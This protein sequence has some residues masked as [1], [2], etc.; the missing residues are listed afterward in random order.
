MRVVRT[1]LLLAAVTG[2]YGMPQIGGHHSDG[3]VDTNGGASGHAGTSP[4]D[5]GGGAADAGGGLDGGAGASDGLAGTFGGGAAGT[6]LGGMGGSGGSNAVFVSGPCIVSPDRASAVEVFAR[7]SDTRIYRRAFDGRNWGSWSAL[8]GLDGTLLDA[9]S[10]LDCAASS[11][12]IHIVAAGV[13]PV[14]SLQHA[15]GFGTTY[16]PFVRE[17]PSVAIAQSPSIALLTNTAFYLGWAGSGQSPALFYFENGSNAVERTPITLLGS[18]VV[19]A[20]DISAQL[21]GLFFAAFDSDGRLAI[22]RH[23]TSS[24][25]AAWVDAT[26]IESPGIFAFSPTVCAESGSSGSFSVN[27]AAVTGHELWFAG[28]DRLSGWPGFSQWVP[29]GKDAVSSPDCVVLRENPNL[30][31][32]IH[33]VMLNTHGTLTDLVGN[34]MSWVTTDLGPPPSR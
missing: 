16:N 7:A 26:T 8:I 28:T 17:L 15:F 20:V 10:D 19:S 29:I 13:N 24:G 14:G 11:D 33:L 22:Y 3:G 9:R 1:V 31:P 4:A 18:S 30:D 34:G 23:N 32:V 21:N 6:G 2:C 27:V 25:G 12:T 5:G